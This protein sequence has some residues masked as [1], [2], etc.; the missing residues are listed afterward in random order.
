MLKTCHLVLALGLSAGLRAQDVTIPGREADFTTTPA[1]QGLKFTPQFPPVQQTAGAPAAFFSCFWEFG[2]GDFSFEENPTHT[3][4]QPGTYSATLD[5]TNNYDDGKKP[6]KRKKSVLTGGG[7]GTAMA[8]VFKHPDQ[9][10]GLKTNCQPKAGEELNCIVS[11]Q[12]TS[13]SDMDGRVHLFFN[14]RKF[15]ESHFRYDTARTYFGETADNSYSS[16]SP[17]DATPSAGWA[18]LAVPSGGGAST[19]RPAEPPFADVREMLESA[20]RAYRSEEAW[21]FAQLRPGEKRNLF[22]S[23]AGTA[24]MLKDTSA[25]IHLEGVFEPFDPAIPPERFELELEIVSSHDPNAIFVSDNRVN[26]RFLRR[27]ELDYKV[28]FQNNGEGPARTVELDIEI[29]DGLNLAR[30]RPVEWYPECPVCPKTPTERSCLDTVSS[31]NGLKFIFRNIYLPGSRQKGVSDRDSTKG[32]V[33]YRIEPE[34]R[35]PKR[36]FSSRAKIVFDKNPPIYTNFSKTRF[37]PGISPGLKAGYAFST[38]SIDA[39]YLFFGA[40][41]SP[42]KSWKIYPQV[43]LL[44]G[45]KGKTT[46]PERQFADSVVFSDLDFKR[47]TRRDSAIT[48]NHSFVS[49]E[50]P[51]LIRKNFSRFFGLGAG[52][53]ARIYLDQGENRTTVTVTRR[54][55]HP[56]IPPKP[57][58]IIRDTTY[59]ASYSAT[60]TQFTVFGDLSLGAVRAGPNLGVRFGAVL[61]ERKSKPFIQASAEWKF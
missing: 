44:S 28:R 2:D 27:K 37:K 21:R 15:P 46:L 36:S 13:K 54:E 59:Q 3:Y 51:V 23:L 8:D 40:S 33:K 52:I 6:R 57:P 22:V 17:I 10:I 19:L 47:I 34:P 58:E 53:S 45:L 30:M 5:V 55:T 18:L 4:L 9:R 29:P 11:Y 61:N 48:G 24:N 60:R 26:Y 7:T 25:F 35:M 31:P 20:R 12:N 1:G 16:I 32:F 43:E 38:D 50:L 39:G 14:E 41:L 56:G 42:F 49:F